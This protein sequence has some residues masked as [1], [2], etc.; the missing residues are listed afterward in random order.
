MN[1]PFSYQFYRTT[2]EAWDAMY[3]AILVAQKSIF[4]EI[5]I[6]I[7]DEAGGRF[8]EALCEK[9]KAG[10]EVKIVVDAIG[11]WGLSSLAQ[12]R[13][14]GSGAEVLRYNR[15]HP[16]LALGKW[17]NRMWRRNHRKLLVVDE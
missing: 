4:W 8:I 16:E 5:Y 17:F 1:K 6:F 13:L 9:A 15:T 11:S 12:A 3:Q 7:D 10:V 2:A 14:V